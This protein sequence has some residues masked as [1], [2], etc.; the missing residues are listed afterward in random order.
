M[1]RKGTV[2]HT[3]HVFFLN[4]YPKTQKFNPCEHHYVRKKFSCPEKKRSRYEIPHLSSCP[5]SHTNHPYILRRPRDIDPINTIF[6]SKMT[7]LSMNEIKLKQYVLIAKAGC[8]GVRGKRD[9]FYWRLPSDA[10]Q[11]GRQSFYLAASIRRIRS[12][13][14]PQNEELQHSSRHRNLPFKIP[15]T[16]STSFLTY[17]T[18]LLHNASL[19]IEVCF[20]EH[21]KKHF[22]LW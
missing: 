8:G 12:K 14:L 4:S 9:K 7:N 21:C 22:H 11:W 15:N 17:S 6:S 5:S 13:C 1:I 16:H 2:A 10:G 18:N 3:A 20:I 19:D